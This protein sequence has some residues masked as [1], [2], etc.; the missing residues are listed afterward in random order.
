MS[1]EALTAIRADAL[2]A[3]DKLDELIARIDAELADHTSI[4][5][6][7]VSDLKR[8]EGLRLK[9][10]PD[11]LSGGPPWTIGYGHTGPEVH[12]GLVWT[13]EQ[14]ETA[15]LADIE[16]HNSKLAA[17]LPWVERL[18][19]ARRRVLQNMAFN[20]GVGTPGGTK[21]LLGFKN[22]LAMIER[23]E[24]ARA[25]DAMLKSLWASQVGQ[26]AVRLSKTMRT[27]K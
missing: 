8:D 3:R 15:L 6:I 25:A 22:T 16:E 1:R 20:L 2:L 21:G 24:Y 5:P 11:P 17:A 12:K 14:A 23:G 7:L 9:A 18:D 27:G 13:Q 10:Y 4:D 19:P 26:R